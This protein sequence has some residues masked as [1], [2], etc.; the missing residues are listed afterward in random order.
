MAQRPIDEKIV[1]MKLDNSDFT[2]KA[3]E[4]TTIFGKM[5]DSLSKIPGVNLSKT[6]QELTQ[7]NQTTRGFNLDTIGSSLQTITG[8]FS[9]LGIVG[10]TALTNI[11]NRAVDAGINLANSLTM[12]PVMD[13]FREYE[14]KIGAIGTVLSNTEWAGTTLDD[15]KRVLGDLND[16]ADQTVYS[17]GQMTENIG[18]FTAAGVSIDDS[19]TAIKGLSNLAAASGSDVNQLNTAMYQM[20]QSMASGTMNL[21]D[22]NSLVNAGMGGKKTQDALLETAKAMGVNVKMADGFRNSISDGWLTSEIFLETMKKFGTD[23]SMTEAATA[24]RTFTGLMDSLKEGIGSG[25]ATT[26]ELIFGDF[27]EATKFWTGLSESITGFFAGFTNTRNNLLEGVVDK[28]GVQNL[29]EGIQNVVKAVINLFDILGAAAN[30]VFPPVTVDKIV[31][32]TKSFLEFSKSLSMSSTTAGKFLTIFQ[33]GF[34]ILSTIIEIAKALGSAIFGIVPSGAGNSILNFLVTLS[35]MAIKFNQSVKAGNGL[36]K[37]IEVIGNVIRTVGGY[38]AG[39]ITDISGFASSIRA[40]IGPV[41]D[42]LADKLS[43]LGKIIKDTFMG[44]NDTEALGTGG[45]IALAVGIKFAIDKITG[46]FDDGLSFVD[47]IKDMFDNLG[48]AIGS[49]TAG[50]KLVSLLAIASAVGILAVSLKLMESI[51][52]EDIVKGITSLAVSLGVMMGAMVIIDKFSITGG[53]RASMNIIA[54]ALAVTIVTVAL[55]RL[56]DIDPEELKKSV[57]ALAGTVLALSGG[58]ALMS[59]AGSKVKTSSAQLLA[60][61]GAVY[62]LAEAITTMSSIPSGDLWE[63]IGAMT[64]IFAA[65][66]GFLL[67]VNKTKFGPG[68]AIGVLAVSGAL[69]LMVSAIQ[70]IANIDTA[71]LITGLTAIAVILAQ[72]GLFSRLASGPNLMASGVGMLLLAG[73]IN[74]LMPP[75]QTLAGMSWEELLKGLGGM[76]LAMVAIA[77]AAML[78]NGAA[79]GV[80]GM[81]GMAAALNLMIGPIQTLSQMTWGELIKGFVGLAGGLAL[82]AGLSMLLSPAVVPMLAF[83]AAL[84]IMG[85]AVTAVGAGVALFGVGLATLASLTAVSVAAIVSSLG[86]LLAGFATLIPAA[87]NFVVELGLALID[88]I[89]RLVP[90]AAEAIVTLIVSL[91]ETI[92][93]HLPKFLDV[94]VTIIVQILE[95]IGQYVPILMDTML[96]VVY[97]LITG[98]SAAIR[99]NGPQLVSAIMELVSEILIL[100]I[101]AGAQMITALLGWIPGVKDATANIGQA[102]EE[103]LRDNFGASEVGAE[104]GTD[105]AKSLSSKSGEVKTAGE[106]LASSAKSGMQTIET[107]S[108]GQ[109]IGQQLANGINSKR[110]L[111]NNTVSNLA[112]G[113]L[114][115]MRQTLD[116]HSPSKKTDKIG[117]DTGQGFANG[118]SKKKKAAE[119]AAKKTATAAQKAFTER[120]EAAKF[121][122][123]MEEISSAQYIKELEK[124]K[125]AY[126]KTPANIRKVDKEIKK[127]REQAAKEQEEIFKKQMDAEK[128]IID[129][130]KY[131]NNLSLTQELAAWMKVLNKYKRGTEER[132]QADREVYRIKNEINSKLIETNENYLSK[133]EEA[134]QREIDGIKSLNQEYEDAVKSRADAIASSFGLFEKIDEMTEVSGQELLDNL[135]GQNRVI[136]DWL[137]SIWALQNRKVDTNLLDALREM[138]PKSAAE[139]KAIQQM[140]EQQLTE[141]VKEFQKKNQMA[142]NAATIELEDLKVETQKK[143]KELQAETSKQL[144][145]YRNEWLK[146]VKEIR[147]GTKEGFIGLNEDM[148]KVGTDVIAGLIKGLDNKK[149]DLYNSARG[150]AM[151]MITEI[152]KT[153][154]VKSPSRV[155]RRIG[156]FFGEGVELGVDDSTGGVVNSVKNMAQAASG[157]LN[158]FLDGIGSDI[159]DNELHFKAI[160]DYDGVDTSKFGTLN[161]V[162][163]LPDL[164][165]V[166]S[167]IGATKSLFGQNGNTKTTTDKTVQPIAPNESDNRPK[168]PV[169]IQI[170]MNSRIVA[171][172]TFDD[173]NDLLR[174]QANMDYGMRGL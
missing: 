152:R 157:A 123:E 84:L 151:G 150:M 29:F 117:Q 174:S 135:K 105:F 59:A 171:E 172:E 126:A 94:G 50:V 90:A 119:A 82:L 102:A 159:P 149:G 8:R 167:V 22:W 46:I 155:A 106:K 74:A 4:T 70:K 154:E 6:N 110:T 140:T 52:S 109:N 141:Y 23:K 67:L 61:A 153:L 97:D 36:T 92:A 77:G 120:M 11:S 2:R 10:V 170:P 62:I 160:I 65:L 80:V 27:E 51:K 81:I 76:A 100:V 32:I 162:A 39:A 66:A 28:G 168:Q 35:H 85:A 48:E 58:I 83:G 104:K 143:I 107:Y 166:N 111:I 12:D 147:T 91:L 20:S 124:I 121:K 41:I 138:G 16:Y 37:A 14:T 98:L 158:E 49:F 72:I 87:I 103:Y 125:K 133:V 60:L 122:F 169:I 55:K 136:D 33:G 30:R 139:V 57:L 86:L 31:T 108:V 9:N 131:H 18:R 113:T 88:G 3:Q 165:F 38:I 115:T 71:E 15:V 79:L 128:K 1:V 164:S 95:G 145:E 114:G 137:S 163:M 130:R 99:D 56:A 142:K 101:E 42:W 116:T 21:M 40:N 75:I 64:V 34:S 19:A 54:L 17:F 156:G 25:W 24:V 73:A 161:P 144:T 13:G 96:Q 7:M 89:I 63:S 173:V 129:E 5:R 53:M 43:P 112:N 132:S 93:T 146:K 44:L 26:W 69:H 68:S 47:S 127:L 45:I 78:M 118:I 148:S 134:N